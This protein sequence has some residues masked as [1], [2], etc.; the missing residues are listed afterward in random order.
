MSPLPAPRVS[1]IVPCHDHARYLPD[2]VNSLRAQTMP[3]WECLVVDDGSTDDT[4]QV[5]ARLAL[6]DS[7]VRVLR[8]PWRGCAPARNTGLDAACGQYLQFLDADDAILP[9]KLAA[10]LAALDG[11]PGPALAICDYYNAPDHDLAVEDTNPHAYLSPRLEGTRPLVD[12]AARWER[13]LSIPAHCFLFDRRLFA[14]VRFDESL[15]SHEDWDCW[16]RIFALDPPVRFVDQRLAVY[17]RHAASMSA[18][19]RE[20]RRSFLRAARRRRRALRQDPVLFAVLTAKLAE[21]ERI[22]RDAGPTERSRRAATRLVPAAVRR[23]LLRPMFLWL[24]R[25]ASP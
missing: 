10:Q 3:S 11:A 9:T 18:D 17:R 4:P 2:A 25:W 14:G 5:A 12:L 22:Y 21:I 8:Q 19:R 7:R 23:R 20:M 16:M 15:S 13:S 1:V 24:D 6:Q